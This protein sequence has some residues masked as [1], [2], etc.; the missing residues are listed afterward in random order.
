LLERGT[1]VR[2]A[3][4]LSSG[5]WDN[6]H[7]F[8]HKM[9]VRIGDLRTSTFT[10]C[11]MEGVEYVFHLAAAHGGRGYIDTHPAD[12]STNMLLDGMVL[13][14][15]YRAGI[16]HVT[17]ASSACVYPV[18]VYDSSDWDEPTKVLHLHEDMA[19]PWRM[20]YA[21]ADSQYGWAKLMGEMALQAYIEQ[22]WLRGAVC[23][24]HTTYGPRENETHAIIAFI[25]KAFVKQDPFQ[26]WGNGQQGRNF[27]YVTD[28]AEGMVRAAECI[29]DG[30][31]VNIA[32]ADPIKMVDL[33]QL[34]CLLMDH[35]PIFEFQ[36]DKPVGVLNRA[37]DITRAWDLMGW[38]P[39]VALSNGLKRTI[40]WYVDT[41]NADEVAS[42]LESLLHE[43]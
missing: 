28:A 26:I 36:R 40:R 8:C 41:H 43:R 10:A 30:T 15:A 12:C 38:E 42:R 4:D 1:K 31:P 20:G 5:R 2:I 22:R 19:T 34:V 24:F 9:D 14:Q 3:D 11:C 32:V 35:A 18:T 39:K 21:L 27:I 23:R 17:L 7:D 6:I 29:S 25:A 13:W 16:K 37:A 33:A